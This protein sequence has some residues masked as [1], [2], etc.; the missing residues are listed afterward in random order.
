MNGRYRM[1][2]RYGW[3]NTRDEQDMD[4]R[5]PGEKTG[6]RSGKATFPLRD[7]E[8]QYTLTKKTLLKAVLY[9]YF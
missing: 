2:G 3:M 1:Y 5:L 9:K 7:E 6:G 4:W 8:M